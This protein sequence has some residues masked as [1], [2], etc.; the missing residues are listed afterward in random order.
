MVMGLGFERRLVRK[1]DSDSSPTEEEVRLESA[2]GNMRRE[3]RPN[4]CEGVGKSESTRACS[5]FFPQQGVRGREPTPLWMELS[6]T[7]K[8]SLKRYR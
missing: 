7:S 5:S 2:L 4:R 3:K 6:M 1:A 8:T